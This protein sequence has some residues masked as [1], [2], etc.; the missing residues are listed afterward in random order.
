MNKRISLSNPKVRFNVSHS[1]KSILAL[2]LIGFSFT[3]QAQQQLILQNGEI[4]DVRLR[5]IGH[6][7][8][9]YRSVENDMVRVFQF[10]E[11][12]RLIISEDSVL[13]FAPLH[14]DSIH[15][16]DLKLITGKV[17]EIDHRFLYYRSYENAMPQKVLLEEVSHV[18]Y[19]KGVREN[20]NPV[21]EFKDAVHKGGL[22]IDGLSGYTYG[23]VKSAVNSPYSYN[24]G[25]KKREG[26]G[27]FIG[28][29]FGY[30]FQ[31]KKNDKNSSFG[32]GVKFL[33]IEGHISEDFGIVSFSLLN[34]GFSYAH[35][36]KNKKS[37]Y[38]LSLNVGP[39]ALIGV[40]GS[41]DL[42]MLGLTAR[43]SSKL[44]IRKNTIGIFTDALF[45][46]RR[47][48]GIV[49]YKHVYTFGVSLGMQL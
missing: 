43:L 28:V 40:G 10:Y 15:L 1:V 44:R 17:T 8:L 9:T 11:I 13:T 35:L 33:G 6:E 3:A 42:S 26:A 7:H 29:Q 31:I 19:K 21:P 48:N 30:N 47:L 22:Y 34:P 25:Y 46:E 14:E 2:I 27:F 23:K 38:G 45:G 32:I 4:I 20:F 37:A 18:I 41:N 12:D 36:L 16:R 5:A 39:A 24:G 49:Y